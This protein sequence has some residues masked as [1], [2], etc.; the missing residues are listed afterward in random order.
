MTT[1]TYN[2]RPDIRVPQTINGMAR[3]AS[4]L[5][6]PFRLACSLQMIT[7]YDDSYWNYFHPQV[8]ILHKHSF[9]LATC[10]DLLQLAVRM[11]GASCSPKSFP[12]DITHARRSFAEFLAERLRKKLD[13]VPEQAT[14]LWGA[15]IL[16][17]LEIFEK[18]YSTHAFQE[19][20]TACLA[21]NQ[22][23][24][25]AIG[26]ID[27]IP[28][29]KSNDPDEEW[30]QWIIKESASRLVFGAFVFNSVNA[31]VFNHPVIIYYDQLRLLGLPL[32]NDGL[33]LTTNSSEFMKRR[34][35]PSSDLHPISFRRGLQDLFN[36]NPVATQYFGHMILMA[37]LLSK[38]WLDGQYDSRL[39]I[40]LNS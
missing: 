7:E 18:R 2:A 15:S 4:L 23:I 12:L 22:V 11:I 28:T 5:S 9:N 39:R 29:S 13:E 25:T 38:G 21:L 30:N 8:P 33:W 20:S 19:R 35:L 37:G 27:T 3:M 40:A 36:G 14:D 31:V 10:P 24:E 16:L 1:G 26:V 34:A 6:P 32:P 17:H